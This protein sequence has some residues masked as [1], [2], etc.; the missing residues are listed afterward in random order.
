[1]SN[2]KKTIKKAVVQSPKKNR[3]IQKKKV[4]L[5]KSSNEISM[6]QKN[7]GNQAVQRLMHSGVI[8]A[9]LTIGQP[10]DKYE[11]E[12]DRVSNE[13]MRM[14]KPNI[15][16]KPIG[17][18]ITPRIQRQPEA[19]EEELIQTK[20]MGETPQVTSSL[21]SKINAL[22]GGGE[23]L[24]KETKGFFEPRFGQDFSKVRVHN[25]SNAHHLARSINARAF[26]RGNNVVFGGGE[27]SPN[28][29]NGKR[30]LGHELTHVVQRQNYISRQII[31]K[32]ADEVVQGGEQ[33]VR[34]QAGRISDKYQ[35]LLIRYAGVLLTFKSTLD[36]P[37]SKGVN[38]Q[39]GKV[40]LDYVSDKVIGKIA[41]KIPGANYVYDIYKAIKTENKNI[42]NL[43]KVRDISQFFKKNNKWITEQA[44]LLKSTETES[45]MKAVKHYNSLANKNQKA[46]YWLSLKLKADSLDKHFKEMTQNK[47]FV[48]LSEKWISSSKT[49]FVRNI[50]MSAY[51]EIRLDANFK[52]TKAHI[53][54]P[55]GQKIADEFNN[56]GISPLTLRVRKVIYAK[57][58]NLPNPY[59]NT[60]FQ[61]QL[62]S[63]NH[64]SSDNKK[65]YQRIERDGISKTNKWSGD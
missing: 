20:S 50:P 13:V 56:F 44:S 3:T 19:K 37:S 51:I 57:G 43:Q 45:E 7:M 22:E 34:N 49:T 6:L 14:P 1:M 62:D 26:T 27:Y 33:K 4:A 53:H 48:L 60:L 32:T 47:I 31:P 15:Q 17:K 40:L 16:T 61:V 10:N 46:I 5:T 39:I 25:D 58:Y 42:Q 9:K 28:S 23:P 12:A 18:Q 38:L 65:L 41:T 55:S 64:Y 59:Q 30:L 36:A 52:I 54:S 11:Q 8:Q 63:N 29:S 2:L 21:E 24:S 35:A